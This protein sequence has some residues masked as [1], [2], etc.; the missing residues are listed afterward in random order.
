[1]TIEVALFGA[2]RI[3]K[4]H[5][6]NLARQPGVRLRYVVDVN[7]QAASELAARHG[8]RVADV[9]DAIADPAIAVT[10]VCSSTDTHADLILKSAEA[11]KHVFC[12]KPVDLTLERARQCAQAVSAAG[13]VSMIGFQRRFD[14]T[15]SAVKR[16]IDTGEI[17]SPEM[18]IVTSRDPG[19][20]P[21]DYIRH[22][23]GIFKDMLIHDFDVF[24]WILDD[25]AE[26]VHATGSCLSDRR[27][28]DAGDVDST[29]V[30][31]RT[32][33]GRLCQINTARRAA[34]GY[35]QR[36]EV[37]GSDGMLQAGNLRPTEVT[38]YAKDAVS[39]DLPEA[40]FLER[41]RQAYAL[42]IEHFFAAI[43]DGEPV[44]TTVADGVKALELAEAATV[45]AREG[46]IVRVDEF[47]A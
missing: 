8:A 28:A 35:D 9:D 43:R 20:P 38:A 21:L 34:Y 14:P 7:E 23:G 44:R 4:I 36:F 37:L 11:R 12:E 45:S 40:F 32:T 22:S 10:V 1:M 3:G 13:V 19:A 17:G 39:T 16:R 2:G 46:R 15:F 25:E 33:K 24:R 30:T 47:R 5:A 31:I 42:E 18:L 6:A 26:T 41:Y 29:A 27:I